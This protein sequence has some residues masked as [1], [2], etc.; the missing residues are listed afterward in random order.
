M[1]KTTRRL[2]LPL[3]RG[4]LALGLLAAGLPITPDLSV[5]ALRAQ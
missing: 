3:A 2:L 4:V 1:L 5:G